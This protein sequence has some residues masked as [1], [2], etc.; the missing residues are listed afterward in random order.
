MI[1]SNDTINL[2][3]GITIYTEQATHISQVLIN[4]LQTIPARF[5]LLCGVTGQLIAARGEHQQIDLVALGSLV[6]GDLAASQEIARLTGE[7]QAYQIILR[8]GESSH[9]FIA[10]AGNYLALMVQVPQDVPL[11]WARV[12]IKQAIRRLS[13]IM[14][15]AEQQ[16]TAVPA[17]F[18]FEAEGDALSDLFGD[19][20]DDIWTE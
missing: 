18:A 12:A 5:S 20:L 8:E 19:A 6:A 11:G 7:Y 1:N 17:D 14:E 9:T 2:R 3:S 15:T 13:Q 10:E 16:V 4:L